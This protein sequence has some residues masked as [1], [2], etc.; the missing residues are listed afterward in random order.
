MTFFLIGLW[1]GRTSEFIFFG[2]VTGGGM[3]INKLWQLGLARVMGGKG[4]KELAKNAIY[5][6]L[7]RGL[8]FSLVRLHALLVLE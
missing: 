2:M 5:V 1:H 3:S 4:Y 8:N 7:G 6:A